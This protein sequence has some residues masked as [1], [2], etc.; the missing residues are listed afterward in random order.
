MQT[1]LVDLAA[2]SPIIIA[3]A[4]QMTNG[5]ARAETILGLP[6]TSG[7]WS[8]IITITPAKAKMLLAVGCPQRDIDKANVAS[9]KALIQTGQ[10]LT[11]HQ[12][13]AFNSRGEMIDGQHRSLACVEADEPIMVQASFNQP[14]VNFMAFDRGKKRSLV[15]DIVTMGIADGSIAPI[16]QAAG[17]LL[18]HFHAGRLPWNLTPRPSANDI[19]ALF[20]RHALL[21]DTARW[22]VSHSRAPK[23]PGGPYAAFLTLFREINESMAMKFAEQISIG[24]NI[25]DRD[26]AMVLRNS[27]ASSGTRK[28][29]INRNAFMVRFVRAWNNHLAGRKVASLS[30]ALDDGNFPKISGYKA[31]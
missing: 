28:V 9:F 11:T 29:K 26:P 31:R 3:G 15:D 22:V 27:L 1:E 18:F 2:S 10:F 16:A 8:C 25:E 20:E 7:P 24:A 12:G 23:P 17:R 19:V 5:R 21:L 14:D 6:V 30:S 13:F 4:A